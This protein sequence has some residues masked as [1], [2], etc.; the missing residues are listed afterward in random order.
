[1]WLVRINIM[2]CYKS[3]LDENDRK[4]PLKC[5]QDSRIRKNTSDAGAAFGNLLIDDES[6]ALQ[7]K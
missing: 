5:T 1:M 3:V 7:N 2:L 6:E 4:T